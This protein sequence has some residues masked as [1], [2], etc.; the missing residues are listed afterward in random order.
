M[1]LVLCLFS[2]FFW[3]LSS[4]L[5]V[6][7]LLFFHLFTDPFSFPH[8]PA[9]INTAQTYTAATLTQDLTVLT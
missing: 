2:F 7:Y 9:V 5:L 4:R 6:Y 1:W 8:V 3:P